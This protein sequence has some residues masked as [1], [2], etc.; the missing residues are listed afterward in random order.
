MT[1][2]TGIT[3]VTYEECEAE[4]ESRGAGCWG[5]HML[6]ERCEYIITSEPPSDVEMFST[7]VA[8]VVYKKVSQVWDEELKRCMGLDFHPNQVTIEEC[9]RECAIDA[10][11][12]VY[13][14]YWN[15]HVSEDGAFECYRGKSWDCSNTHAW[16]EGFQV[17]KGYRKQV[18]E[19]VD[20]N[21]EC[22]GLSWDRRVRSA[23][24]CHGNCALDVECEVWMWR[25]E[26]RTC[27]RGRADACTAGSQAPAASALKKVEQECWNA[28]PDCERDSGEICESCGTLAGTPMLCCREDWADN[29]PN[30]DGVVYSPFMIGHHHC[31]LKPESASS[32]VPA[33]TNA[34]IEAPV[35]SVTRRL[36]R[37]KL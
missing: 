20:N 33:S 26:S 14:W 7:G 6:N 9:E 21:K 8:S 24:V 18:V 29:H 16:D 11:C 13:Q 32:D 17:A 36:L 28:Y 23:A 4:C 25:D 19:W 27:W 1:F 5:F 34:P 31:V 10:S 15:A 35:E 30:C 2:F 12:D 22:S 3:S 37:R